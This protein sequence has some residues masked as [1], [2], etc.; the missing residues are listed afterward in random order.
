MQDTDKVKRQPAGN[1]GH[2]GSDGTGMNCKVSVIV[3]VYN[4]AQYIVRCVDSLMGQTLED[5]E[6]IFVDDCS[7]DDTVEV[8]ERAT[9]L[10]PERKDRVR[11]IHL[12]ENSGPGIARHR[13]FVQSTGAFIMFVDIDDSIDSEMASKMYKLAVDNNAEL[14][15]CGRKTFFE[16]G[17]LKNVDSFAEA[18]DKEQYFRHYICMMSG[19]L[20][21]NITDKLISRRL[22]ETVKHIPA[23][24]IA[25]DWALCVQLVHKAEHIATTDEALYHYHIHPGSLFHFSTKEEALKV[26][27]YDKA[28]IDLVISYLEE[29]GLAEKYRYE[30]EARKYTAKGTFANMTDDDAMYRQWKDTY[31]EVNRS[32]LFNPYMTFYSRKVYLLKWFRI[33]RKYRSIMDSIQHFLKLK[34]K[35]EV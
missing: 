1:C 2:P 20:S 6:Y 10:Y 24:K 7:T 22:M 28:N 16:D 3:P 27:E 21:A 18:G 29:E 23:G 25:E 4:A 12:E 8:L 33:E 9:A 15:C 30:I 13:G 26:A 19:D 17:R 11:I 32:I 34:K 31:R 35:Y 5:I 14:V